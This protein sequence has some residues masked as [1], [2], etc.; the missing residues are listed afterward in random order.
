MDLAYTASGFLVGFIVG[1][2]GVGGGSLMT[3][4]LVILF[5]IKP[6]IAVGT[7]LLYAAVTK[8]GGIWVHHWQ[9]TVN[10]K[11]TGLLAAGSLP[12]SALMV[13]LLEYF[14]TQGLTYDGLI[15]STLGAA[16]ILASLVLLFKFRL[17]EFGK[18]ER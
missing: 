8:A 2:T 4:I 1:L 14:H 13:V 5:G 18:N 10:W 11:I 15:T 12:T 16:L 9:R 17:L 3:P 6:A 7:D